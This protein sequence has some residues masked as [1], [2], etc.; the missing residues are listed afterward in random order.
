MIRRLVFLKG[1]ESFW[2]W[3]SSLGDPV[4]LAG[5]QNPRTNCLTKHLVVGDELALLAGSVFVLVLLF[6]IPQRIKRWVFTGTHWLSILCA[7][8]INFELNLNVVLKL[9]LYS[10]C[11]AERAI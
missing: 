7:F 8:K 1:V 5:H 6:S 2:M 9:R 10:P 11:F 3:D 4:R